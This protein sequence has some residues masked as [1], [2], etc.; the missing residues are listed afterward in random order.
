MT[1]TGT[2]MH[3]LRQQTTG[4]LPKMMDY[5]AV[6]LFLFNSS[7]IPPEKWVLELQNQG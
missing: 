1:N 5:R 4:W 3:A 7:K 2:E 6:Y